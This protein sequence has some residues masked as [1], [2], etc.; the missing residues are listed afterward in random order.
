MNIPLIV[1]KANDNGLGFYTPVKLTGLKLMLE[2]ETNGGEVLLFAPE[3]LG[4]HTGC[5]D[6][7]G[8]Y[9]KV[10]TMGKYNDC[11]KCDQLFKEQVIFINKIMEYIKAWWGYLEDNLKK[12]VEEIYK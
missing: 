9:M 2:V 7:F 3:E 12:I 5:D 10:Y 11:S 1:I 6:P 8:C 4:P